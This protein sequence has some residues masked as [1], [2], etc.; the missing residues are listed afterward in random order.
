MS[1]MIASDGVRETVVRPIGSFSNNGMAT[2]V[3][4]ERPTLLQPEEYIR[5]FDILI[6][7][8]WIG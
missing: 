8:L 1:T 4:R 3:L 6:L 7:D 5:W 2:L